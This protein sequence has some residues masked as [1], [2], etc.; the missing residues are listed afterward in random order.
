MIVAGFVIGLMGSLHCVGMCG[1]IAMMVNGN[2]PRLILANRIL[3]NL[4]RIITYVLMGSIVGLMGKIVQ[5]G[6]MQGIVSLVVGVIIIL[7]IMIPNIK[8]LFMPS[9]SSSIGR[10]KKLFSTHLTSRKSVSALFTGIL[11]GYLPCGLVYGALALALVQSTPMESA[12]IMLLFGMGTIPA[13]LLAAYSWQAIKKFIPWSFQR[14]QTAMLVVVAVVMIWRGLSSE[15]AYHGN[16]VTTD[17][18]CTP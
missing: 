13:M 6:G 9:L 15:L 5:W 14:I 4:G 8:S 7:M 18:I 16:E 3:Y 11:N 17:V 1:P 2:S 12:G 10:I